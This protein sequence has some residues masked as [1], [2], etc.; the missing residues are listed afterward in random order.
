MIPGS[1]EITC[2]SIF[3]DKIIFKLCLLLYKGCQEV[4]LLKQDT[5]DNISLYKLTKI[6][7]GLFVARPWV[8]PSSTSSPD[9][10][11]SVRP[12]MIRKQDDAKWGADRTDGRA[13]WKRGPTQ[14]C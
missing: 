11:G 2:H 13:K 5:A 3:G 8:G 14:P 12:K 4:I 6:S 1:L 7:V 10:S 9:G